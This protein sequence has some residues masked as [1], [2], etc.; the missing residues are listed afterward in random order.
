MRRRKGARSLK[1]WRRPCKSSKARRPA[2]PKLSTNPSNNIAIASRFWRV[3][4][5]SCCV[6][7][8]TTLIRLHRRN[9]LISIDGLDRCYN[10]QEVPN[11]EKTHYSINTRH[12]PLLWREDRG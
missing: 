4:S 9:R 3:S 10:L 6:R 8:S 1:T 7:P 2:G 5:T 11:E 12:G